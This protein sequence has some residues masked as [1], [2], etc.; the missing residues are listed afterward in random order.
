MMAMPVMLILL[1]TGPV[2]AEP[3]PKIWIGPLQDHVDPTTKSISWDYFDFPAMLSPAAPWQTAASRIDAVMVNVPHA[4]EGFSQNGVPSLPDIKSMLERTA[5]H[6]GGGGAV[7]YTAGACEL[8][9][10]EGMTNDT[11]YAHEVVLTTRYWHDAGMPLTYFIM[12][13]P[14]YFGHIYT[15]DQCHLAIQDVAIRAANTAKQIRSLYPNVIIVDADGPGAELPARWLPGYHTFLDAFRQAYGKPID[16]LDMDLHWTDTWHTGYRWTTAATQIARDMHALGVRVSLIVNA[17][18]QNWDPDVPP[19]PGAV[20]AG[21]GAMT[22]EYWM[23]AVRKHIDLIRQDS[24]PL[25]AI[26][27]SSWMKFPRHNLP[28][29]DP[30]AWTAL[31]NYAHTTLDPV[32]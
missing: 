23:A 22:Q 28:E 21:P 12:D 13:S 16:Y 6:A 29:T 31:I 20:K 4:A 2:Q 11:D 25:D 17:E 27:L 3:P 14:Y 5:V 8:A 26:D 9:G 19:P 10:V 24:I 30:L 18:D 1:A 15:Q 7:V 32:K